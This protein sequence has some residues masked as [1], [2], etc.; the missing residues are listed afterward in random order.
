MDSTLPSRL[1][2]VEHLFLSSNKMVLQWTNL[3]RARLLKAEQLEELTWIAGETKNQ[4]NSLKFICGWM[5]RI[6][7]RIASLNWTRCDRFR[8]TQRFSATTLRD[9]VVIHC[10]EGLRLTYLRRRIR[11][12]LNRLRF[13]K[14]R[15]LSWMCKQV[16]TL[17]QEFNRWNRWCFRIRNQ[18]KDSSKL[19]CFQESWGKQEQQVRR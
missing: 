10:N 17:F 13:L 19:S 8:S 12:Y 7:L 9:S 3:L 18:L 16:W 4:G 14:H 5:K 6:H 11:I 1:L 2:R 15:F